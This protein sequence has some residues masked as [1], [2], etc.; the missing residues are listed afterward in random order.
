MPDDDSPDSDFPALYTRLAAQL[1]HDEAMKAWMA[2]LALLDE[3]AK[4][5]VEEA[6]VT[7]GYD[8]GWEEWHVEVRTP[9]HG[10]KII[11]IPDPQT[12]DQDTA[13]TLAEQ[14]A[15][16][17]GLPYVTENRGLTPAAE[18]LEQ[19]RVAAGVPGEDDPSLLETIVGLRVVEERDA[20]SGWS[21][22][23][24]AKIILELRDGS[25]KYAA[26][27][28]DVAAIPPGQVGVGSVQARTYTPDEARQ[29]G[30]AFIAAA[31]RAEK[32]TAETAVPVK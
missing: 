26:A 3:P 14:T 21:V 12:P 9:G 20:A 8:P 30:V 15:V 2:A 22:T 32:L 31:K 23:A 1:G 29:I 13:H 17:Y 28:L 25:A 19:I 27:G 4:T 7:V 24:P 10:M 16:S 6:S 11:R 18:L 5:G